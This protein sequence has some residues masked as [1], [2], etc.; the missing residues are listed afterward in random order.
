MPVL[1]IGNAQPSTA[2][3]CAEPDTLAFSSLFSGLLSGLFEV[4]QHPD[5]QFMPI[6][7]DNS[8]FAG[9]TREAIQSQPGRQ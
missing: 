2:A 8:L 7:S 5:F 9:I 4:L 3:T 6:F 1:C